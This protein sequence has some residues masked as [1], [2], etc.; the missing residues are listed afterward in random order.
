MIG[1]QRAALA[2]NRGG[3][4]EPFADVDTVSIGRIR[5]DALYAR[6]R[7]LGAKKIGDMAAGAAAID[8]VAD[9]H[10]MTGAAQGLDDRAGATGGSHTASGKLSIP[11][12]A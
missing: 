7:R 6:R 9:D 12:K 3:E 5:D 2:L 4:P 8:N 10:S 1:R 11:S